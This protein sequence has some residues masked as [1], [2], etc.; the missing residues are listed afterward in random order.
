MPNI[1]QFGRG[2]NNANINEQIRQYYDDI[3]DLSRQALDGEITPRQ[4]ENRMQDIVTAALFM[5]FILAG[6]SINNR[7]AQ[8]Y[9]DEQ[10]RIAFNSISTLSTDIFAGSYSLQTVGDETI[11]TA[12]R[13]IEKLGNRLALW[14][15]ALGRVFNQSQL[16]PSGTEPGIDPRTGELITPPEP[17]KIWLYDPR[18]EHCTD[19]AGLNNLVLT[20]SEWQRLGIEPQSPQLECGGWRCG[21]K[22]QDTDA[23]SMGIESA[24]FGAVLHHLGMVHG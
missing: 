8:L 5:A 24:N 19:C 1:L 17:R 23:P 6:G 22:W 20:I 16:Y 4:Y 11:Q 13:G 18:K 9:L 12:D 10:R 7:N 14:T 21:C 2:N 3:N 15:F